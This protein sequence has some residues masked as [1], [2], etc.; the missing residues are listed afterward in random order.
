MSV[1]VRCDLS[2]CTVVTCHWQIYLRW[3]INMIS[4]SPLTLYI[5]SH[6]DVYL[7]L[8]YIL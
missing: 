5:T 2:M 3:P 6:K 4:K 7:N 8:F 1:S